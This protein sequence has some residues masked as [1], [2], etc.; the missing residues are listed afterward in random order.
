MKYML[1][2]YNSNLKK[3]GLIRSIPNISPCKHLQDLTNFTS[4]FISEQELKSY[5]IQNNIMLEE[6]RNF[7]M[8][9]I[10]IKKDNTAN[11]VRFGITYKNDLPYL[12]EE[13]IKNYFQTNITNPAFLQYFLDNYY[14]Y[15]KYINYFKEE[16]NYIKFA[17]ERLENNNYLEE[18]TNTYIDNFLEHY[19][20]HK[21][22]NTRIRNINQIREL[23]MFIRSYE[24][25]IHPTNNIDE[26]NYEI[27][28]YL[29]IIKE[30]NITDEDMIAYN[31]RI[32][33]LERKLK[34][35]LNNGITKD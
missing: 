34:R 5:L 24:E 32:N 3:Y 15:L 13:F 35:R 30:N 25:N 20:Y 4:Q 11:L 8:Q 14:D 1:I 21:R 2:Y 28:N 17:Y 27:D 26:I 29:R 19:M 16:L 10:A 7:N 33:T 9:I 12:K 18:D 6:Y 31:E 22:N 23:G